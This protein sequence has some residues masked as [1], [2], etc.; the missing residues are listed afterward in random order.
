MSSRAVSK[1]AL[2]AKSL[3]TRGRP[4]TASTARVI[5]HVPKQ[6]SY[7]GISSSIDK[8][9]IDSNTPQRSQPSISERLPDPHKARYRLREFELADRVFIV[10]GGGGGLGLTIAEA[11]VEAGGQVYCLDRKDCPGPE[12]VD[13]QE[14]LAPVYGGALRYR[15][16]DVRNADMVEEAFSGI[17]SK[18][19]RLDGMVAAAGIQ[20]VKRAVDF[21]PHEID[22]ILEVNFRGVY[23]SAVSCARQMI[24][25]EVPGS[26]LLVASMSGM[27]AN[28]GF[29]TS[30]Y[31]ASKAAVVQLSRSL[32]ME[33]GQVVHGKPIRV[34]ALCPGN[35][36]TPMVEKNFK[37]QPGLREAWESQNMLGRISDAREY[38]GAALFALSDA[39]SFMTGSSLVI[40][41]GYTA[42]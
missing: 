12:F 27:V 8:Q 11:L 14:R 6:R 1:F 39:S 3:Q 24:R 37:D 13:V 19:G 4:R 34:N 32:A 20:D 42:W 17:A 15:R 2:P 16:I 23:A 5:P 30:V 18:H 33:W 38:R 41:G 35:I 36:V 10:T 22:R 25:Y 7:G 31:N 29:T 26:V 9:R 40:D 21:R 28:R